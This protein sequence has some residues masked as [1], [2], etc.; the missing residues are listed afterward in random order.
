[1]IGRVD[2][3]GDGACVVWDGRQGS[4]FQAHEDLRFQDT[5][6]W[7]GATSPAVTYLCCS[8]NSGRQCT[9]IPFAYSPPFKFPLI[10]SSFAFTCA[11]RGFRSIPSLSSPLLVPKSAEPLRN[12]MTAT[13]LRLS[14]VPPAEYATAACLRCSVQITRTVSPCENCACNARLTA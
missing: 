13:P 12:Q 6:K 2:L 10:T 11:A 1:M 9:S 3:L 4:R 8:K 5:Q 14:R 7:S